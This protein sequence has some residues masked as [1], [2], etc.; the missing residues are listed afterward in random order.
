MGLG[1]GLGMFCRKF[2]CSMFREKFQC[3][4]FRGKFQYW[5]S[6][7]FD[8]GCF[9]GTVKVHYWMSLWASAVYWMF[10]NTRALRLSSSSRCFTDREI[11][12]Y[13]SIC[14]YNIR[15]IMICSKHCSKHR[16]YHQGFIPSTSPCIHTHIR[17]ITIRRKSGISPYVF[18][19]RDI[20]KGT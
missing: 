15:Y 20:T 13:I 4:M 8:L 17:D 3:W 18:N 14:I 2:Q 5:V 19:I 1:L 12:R 6:Y 9:S 7:T 11:I 10:C 16:V